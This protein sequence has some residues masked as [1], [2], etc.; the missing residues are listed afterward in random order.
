[1]KHIRFVIDGKTHA[2][3]VEGEQVVDH[4]GDRHELASLE[5]APPVQPSKFFGIG[6]NYA[7][8]VQESGLETPAVPIFFN[9]Q[10]TCVVAHGA[11]I[12]RPRASDQLDYEGELG[13]VIG[14]RC[15]HVTRELAP[16]VVAGY[17][18]VN[19]VSV[20]DWQ[21]GSPTWTLGKSWDTHGPIGP[22]LTTAD[23]IEDPHD[24]ELRTYVNGELRQHSNTRHLIF[25]CFDQIAHL[26]T[27][28]TLEPGDVI[29]TGTPGGVGVAMTP[30]RYLE[31]GDVVRIE[32]DGLG[33]L[34]NP[35]T[36]EPDDGPRID[37][38]RASRV[39]RGDAGQVVMD[40]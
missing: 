25:D 14:R 17:L 12:E 21:L 7:D 16:D 40:A 33:A 27:V 4:A 38:R 30:P 13:V 20:R 26:S 24:L 11:A 28:C 1:M 3:T 39:D 18:I 37:G 35:V 29:S 2:G 19:D 34:E 32:I 10:P 36:L 22:W 31:A 23:E 8:H 5:L 9:K 15:R 6:L